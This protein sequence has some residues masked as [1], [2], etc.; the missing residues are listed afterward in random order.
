MKISICV[1]SS[2]HLKGSREVIARIQELIRLHDPETRIELAA[3]FCLGHCAEG[4]SM[5]IDQEPV[6][7]VNA[8]NVDAIFAEKVLAQ[9]R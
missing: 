1:G 7:G 8:E 4:V 3:S 6:Y 2:C 5:M 9:L